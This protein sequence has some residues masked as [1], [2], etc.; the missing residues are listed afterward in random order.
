MS[1]VA[2]SQANGWSIPPYVWPVVFGV[3]FSVHLGFLIYGLPELSWSAKDEAPRTETEVIL[4]TGGL[5]F[6]PIAVIENTTTGEAALIDAE[7]LSPVAAQ[8][9]A[10]QPEALVPTQP[11]SIEAIRPVAAETDRPEVTQSASADVVS[12]SSA[13]TAKVQPLAVKAF[14]PDGQTDADIV[15]PGV[16]TTPVEELQTVQ[17]VKP[18]DAIQTEPVQESAAVSPALPGPSTVVAIKPV[19]NTKT[20]AV[21]LNSATDPPTSLQADETPLQTTLPTQLQSSITATT[22]TVQSVAGGASSITVTP[23]STVTSLAT[24]QQ[25]TSVQSAPAATSV[26]NNSV[27]TVDATATLVTKQP[28]LAAVQA[29]RPLEQHVAA[30][31]PTETE[32]SNIAPTAPAI[33][34]IPVASLSGEPTENVA[35]VEVESIDPLAK[36]S[37]YVD[38]YEAGDCTHLTVMSAGTGSAA[39]TAFG[40]DVT[41]FIKFDRM[42]TADQGYDADIELRLVTRSQCALLNALETGQGVEAAGLVELDRT[43]VRS[44]TSVAG[45]VQR[46]LPLER[47]A[48]AEQAG[49]QLNGKGPPELYIID[50]V[51]QIHDGRRY[52]LPA[53]NAI[54]A[55]G[56]RF[57]VPVT[58]I[59][60]EEEETA[61]VLAIWN[62]PAEKQ[63]PRFRTVSA[64]RIANILENP[65]VFS[66]TAFKVSR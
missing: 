50:D 51:G 46:D 66:L 21:E 25:I 12:T 5:A 16:A 17:P 19:S 56:W 9:A 60:S 23:S 11:A 58:L 45:I 53:S 3:S 24:A 42:F 55:G 18:A 20:Q 34:N 33:S 13:E 47:I 22:P 35:P 32:V 36:V 8:V 28:E 30:I 15:V 37:A 64:S 39:V 7:T 44:G 43:V 14:E 2:Y 1:A 59:S 63:P 52:I 62:R 57:S 6:D 38:G 31:Q 29:V 26:E 49:L 54:T 40:S 4:E 61:L 10:S 41:P 65:G 48:A 27:K